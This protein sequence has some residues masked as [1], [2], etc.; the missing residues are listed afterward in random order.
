MKDLSIQIRKANEMDIT[1]VNEIYNWAVENNVATF[2]LENR[3]GEKAKQ[4]FLS[5]QNP[6]YPLL[7]AE[8]DGKVLGWASISPFHPRPA[9]KSSGEF[10]IYIAPESQ[11]QGVGKKLLEYL[12]QLAEQLGYHTLLGLITGTNLVSLALADKHGF[13]ETGRYC[14]VGEKFGQILDVVVV[15]RIF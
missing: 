12:C 6:Y 3:T 13:K 9:Y 5:H 14:E 10:S 1:Q 4:W 2:D 11:G 7:V 8:K 15:Q